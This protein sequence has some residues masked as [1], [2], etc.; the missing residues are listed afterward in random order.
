M[1]VTVIDLEMNMPSG[2]II[3]IGAVR[4]LTETGQITDKLN[5]YVN[6]GE[7][8]GPYITKL[9]GIT[10]DDVVNACSLEEAYIQ[11]CEFHKGAF[12]NCMTWGGGDAHHL[13]K[14][15]NP[16][17][18][19][20]YPWPFGRRWIDAKT[21]Y[22]AY[23]DANNKK[24]AGGL[25]KAMTKFGLRF[26]GRIHDALDDARNTFRIYIELIKRFKENV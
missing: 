11:L 18:F 10:D 7:P 16:E 2:K 6:P 19:K 20:Q 17:I 9:T 22:V 15:L 12:I 21:L 25:A 26:D 3:Q 13:K 4:G 5:I 8:I 14:Q 23:R 1:I 24:V